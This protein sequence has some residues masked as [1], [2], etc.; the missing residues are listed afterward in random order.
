MYHFQC[1]CDF[2]CSSQFVFALLVQQQN[3]LLHSCG[4]G[5]SFTCP[6][7]SV[8]G[9]V[10]KQDREY[11]RAEADEQQVKQQYFVHFILL[12]ETVEEIFCEEQR[13]WLSQKI[14]GT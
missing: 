11:N 7:I 2:A 6:L 9:I 1:A 5:T 12:E 4:F 14:N 13:A 8:H 10:Q 3:V